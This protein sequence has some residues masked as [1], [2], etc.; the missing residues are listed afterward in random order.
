M[1]K[2]KGIDRHRK[3]RNDDSVHNQRGLS[4]VGL[5][6][7]PELYLRLG[8]P[9]H[10]CMEHEANMCSQ[11]LNSRRAIFVSFLLR[12]LGCVPFVLGKSVPGHH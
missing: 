12:L 9:V 10:D 1:H 4:F 3:R 11:V 7:I 8:F 5:R 6:I 2:A